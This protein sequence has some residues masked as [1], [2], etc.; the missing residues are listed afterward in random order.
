MLIRDRSFTIGQVIKFV[1]NVEA[2]KRKGGRNKSIAERRVGEQS[3]EQKA[4]AEE[5]TP[6]RE[7][8]VKAEQNRQSCAMKES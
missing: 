4:E 6:R 8:E 5:V 7:A 1:I 3:R 2:D